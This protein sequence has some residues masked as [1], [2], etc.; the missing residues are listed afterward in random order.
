MALS[1]LKRILIAIECRKLYS[2]GCDF[3]ESQSA[4]QAVAPGKA[5]QDSFGNVEKLMTELSS[6]EK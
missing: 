4:A 6:F 3:I 1:F 5:F 2:R